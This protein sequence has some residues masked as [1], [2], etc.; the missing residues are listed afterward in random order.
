[1]IN[2][3]L[4]GTPEEL[5]RYKKYFATLPELEIKPWSANYRNRGETVRT[6]L[7]TELKAPAES[8]PV[9]NDVVELPFLIHVSSKYALIIF[10]DKYGKISKTYTMEIREAEERLKKLKEQKQNERVE[11]NK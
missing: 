7:N 2:I 1:M 6:F 8:E 9:R 11:S 5:E 4:E 10:R 3:R